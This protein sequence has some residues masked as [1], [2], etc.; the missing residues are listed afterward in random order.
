MA[1][2]ALGAPRLSRPP[3]QPGQGGGYT[4]REGANLP[5]PAN[6]A[7]PPTPR[8][9]PTGGVA[10][11]KVTGP[12]PVSTTPSPTAATATHSPA[13]SAIM[14]GV[15]KVAPTASTNVAIPTKPSP[16]VPNP[17]GA[18]TLAKPPFTPAPPPADVFGIQQANDKYTADVAEYMRTLQDAAIAYGD[19]NVQQG[20]G[21]S[22]D[23]SPNSALALAA[24]KAQQ[25]TLGDTNALERLGT[26]GSTNALQALSTIRD[27]QQRANL[28]GLTTYQKALGNYDYYT[29][30]AQMAKTNAIFPFQQDI[31]QNALNQMPTT[32]TTPSGAFG[33]GTTNVRSK[34]PTGLAKAPKT[35][36][37]PTIKSAKV[38]TPKG[39]LPSVGRGRAGNVPSN[40][41]GKPPKV[42][43]VS[44]KSARSSKTG[45]IRI[46]P[47]A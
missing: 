6:F 24:Y 27:A 18:P 29:G 35:G 16:L 39:R 37:A 25:S 23:V 33:T 30:A 32:T 46:P 1:G 3:Q 40:K 31:T 14:G 17:T 22:R 20:L 26:L 15:N 42:G 13:Y 44:K 36:K 5:K 7:G 8:Q 43:K 28:A 41:P 2:P 38:P 10:P 12:P 45:G 4:Y 9:T 47:M 19:P 11:S 21:L 34:V